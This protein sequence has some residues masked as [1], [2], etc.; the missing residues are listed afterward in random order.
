MSL[1]FSPIG[2]LPIS[3]YKTAL[4]ALV[5]FYRPDGDVVDGLW[6][7]ST[8]SDLYATI[9]ED[10]P[11]DT[12]YNYTKVASTFEVSLSNQSDP[13]TSIGH[14]IRYR[15]RGTRTIIVRLKQGATNIASWTHSSPP[16][17]FTTFEQVLTTIE[18]DSITDYS[19]LRVEIS[20]T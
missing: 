2:K 19:D 10:V 15:I 18:A 1:G 7:P 3:T 12:D 8:G 13:T 20:T 5:V 11:S 17:S 4:V 14:K 6:L 16:S 9:D